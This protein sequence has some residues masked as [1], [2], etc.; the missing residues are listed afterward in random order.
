MKTYFLFIGFF[1]L[2]QNNKFDITSMK[3][4]YFRE[5]SNLYYVNA[6]ND[7]KGNIYFEFCGCKINTYYNYFIGINSDDE[8]PILF[9]DNNIISFNQTISYTRHSS[10]IISHDNNKNILSYDNK[11]MFFFNLLEKTI[12]YK[13]IY[14]I[15]SEY[16]TKELFQQSDSEYSIIKL[17]DNN[18][19]LSFTSCEYITFSSKLI[20]LLFNF[21]TNNI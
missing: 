14:N 15:L 9:K 1:V 13:G 2:I 3:V 12:I 7:D 16:L 6:L 18:Y 20:M 11:N 8:K 19:L 21:I 17:K 4:N 5:N 10:I